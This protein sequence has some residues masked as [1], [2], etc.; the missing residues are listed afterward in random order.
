M[1]GYLKIN[2][3]DAW[4]SYDAFLCETSAG[5][6]T[7]MDELMKAPK[8]K[9]YTSIEYRER[10]G[11]ELPD[12]LPEPHFEGRDITLQIGILSP[13]RAT[14]IAKYNALLAALRAGWLTIVV[15]DIGTY[16]VY[17]K[18]Y[19]SA[20]V[21]PLSTTSSGKVY[22]SFKIKFRE[23]DPFATIDINSD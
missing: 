13:T 23:P 9:P 16:K 8:M 15:K 22:G 12:V 6:H 7:N 1:T 2:N 3:V 10:T 20:S 4:T 18:E 11:E 21:L 19:S 14:W 17:L 5:S